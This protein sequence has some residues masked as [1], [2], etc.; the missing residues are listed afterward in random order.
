MPP[1]TQSKKR[2]RP[3]YAEALNWVH[4][5]DDT[6]WLDFERHLPSVTVSLIADLFG[7]TTE[8][9]ATDLR[10]LKGGYQS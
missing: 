7:R 8:E 3:V 4:L 1:A 10:K 2:R 5:Y 6:E 9:V